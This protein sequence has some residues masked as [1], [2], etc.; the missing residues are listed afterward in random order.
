M[1]IGTLL[2]SSALVGNCNALPTLPIKSLYTD[3]PIFSIYAIS[4]RLDLMTQSSVSL[5]KIVQHFL[6]EYGL[7][8]RTKILFCTWNFHPSEKNKGKAQNQHPKKKL[9]YKST[10]HENI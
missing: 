2:L 8:Y 5:V 6:P 3:L 4:L 7:F 10:D 1:W 9:G